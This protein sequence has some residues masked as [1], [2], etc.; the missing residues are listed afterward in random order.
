MWVVRSQRLFSAVARNTPKPA[1]REDDL[2]LNHAQRRRDPV[3]AWRST[4]PLAGAVGYE[5]VGAF[6]AAFCR[7]TGVTPTAYFALPPD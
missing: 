3:E 5:S 2:G 4:L 7:E 6:V 1:E